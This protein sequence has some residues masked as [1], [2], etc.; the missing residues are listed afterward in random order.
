HTEADIARPKANEKLSGF[1]PEERAWMDKFIS[2]GFIDTFRYF[3]KEPAQY[4]WWDLKSGARA[5][6]VGWR[7]DYFF[8]SD[9]LMPSVT[10]AFIMKEVMGSDHCPVGITLRVD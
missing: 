7:L 2:H 3:H 6:D 9:N 10:S 4:T 1:L 5:R 8:V